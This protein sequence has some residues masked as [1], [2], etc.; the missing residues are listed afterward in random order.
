MRNIT[1]TVRF[2]RHGEYE[3]SETYCVDIPANTKEDDEVEAIMNEIRPILQD[4][5]EDDEDWENGDMSWTLYS[6]E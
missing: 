6:W 4:E 5:Y 1:A 2:S 3:N